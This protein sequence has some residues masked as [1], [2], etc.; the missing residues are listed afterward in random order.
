[1]KQ[2]TVTTPEQT[3]TETLPPE[4]SMAGDNT[5]YVGCEFIE[6]RQNYGL[7]LYTIKAE[8]EGR[9]VG[10]QDCR[11]PIGN[12][13]CPA[14]KMREEERQAGRALYYQKR[15]I[16]VAVDNTKEA[17][18]TPTFSN[19]NVDKNSLS[20]KRGWNSV[21]GKK[22]SNIPISALPKAPLR[23]PKAKS[24]D[25]LERGMDAAGT[26]TD[27]INDAA[28]TATPSV[29]RVPVTPKEPE[30]P[31]KG[32]SEPVKHSSIATDETAREERRRKARLAAQRMRGEK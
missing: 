1:M 26:M 2:E 5:I 32:P 25:A 6:S 28:K 10:F 19:P 8:E 27:V 9:L 16:R 29:K 21:S 7:C 14:L 12:K 30:K 31:V 11:R 24:K 20:Y 4:A 15:Q 3:T 18:S 13:T 23:K 17:D 22:A